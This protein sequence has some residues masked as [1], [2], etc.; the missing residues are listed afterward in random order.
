MDDDRVRWS[1]SARPRPTFI[2]D[3]R[4]TRPAGQRARSGWTPGRHGAGETE[5]HAVDTSVEAH[6]TVTYE[7]DAGTG[8]RVPVRMEER[9]RRGRD[10]IEVRGVATYSRFRGSRSTPAR[11]IDQVK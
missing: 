6:I 5:L 2:S 7:L 1:N 11:E 10:P 3:D 8:L 4:R 9:Y